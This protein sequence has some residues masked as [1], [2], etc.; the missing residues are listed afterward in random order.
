[1]LPKTNYQH[2]LVAIIMTQ[3]VYAIS[4]PNYLVEKK[5]SVEKKY[6]KISL[7]VSALIDQLILRYKLITRNE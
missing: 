3:S 4:F 2:R 6:P 7:I 5:I 1:M